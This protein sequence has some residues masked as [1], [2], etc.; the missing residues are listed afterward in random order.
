MNGDQDELSSKATAEDGDH[1]LD[2][3]QQKNQSD[4]VFAD[5]DR[6]DEDSSEDEK[7]DQSEKQ[8]ASTKKPGKLCK[9]NSMEELS[10]TLP[11][12]WLKKHEKNFKDANLKK[13]GSL[14]RNFEA[15]L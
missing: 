1:K 10:P 6:K 3:D 8:S 5:D 2:E 9:T 4:R 11:A 14:P 12:I 13:G 7:D 15:C